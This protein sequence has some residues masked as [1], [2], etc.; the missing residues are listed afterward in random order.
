MEER[1]SERERVEGVCVLEMSCSGSVHITDDMFKDKHA[2]TQ[3][4]YIKTASASHCGAEGKR[5]LTQVRVTC[6]SGH[7]YFSCFL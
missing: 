7:T 4:I 5:A 6:T 2:Q 1:E 3:I